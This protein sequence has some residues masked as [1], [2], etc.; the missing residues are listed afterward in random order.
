MRLAMTVAL[1]LAASCAAAET[2]IT[3]ATWNVESDADTKPATISQRM[4]QF[5]D[6]HL[7]TLVE[8]GSPSDAERYRRAV[9]QASGRNYQLILNSAKPS[10]DDRIAF[11]LDAT[12]WRLV[13]HA[14]ELTDL[15][16]Q[17][18][19][20]HLPQNQ[21]PSRFRPTFVVELQPTGWTGDRT[22]VVAA[23]HL[24]R[25]QG[26][27]NPLRN[28]QAD[29]LNGL[30]EGRISPG[31]GGL[32]DALRRK[33]PFLAMGD[34]NFDWSVPDGPGNGGFAALT[35]NDVFAWVRPAV[36][37][38]T[39]CSYNSI[40]DFVFRANSAKDWAATSR[41]V[42]PIPGDDADAYCKRDSAGESDH[43]IVVATFKIGD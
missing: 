9:S 31:P 37:I 17:L 20:L 30:V 18:C 33:A 11:L 27:E 14:Y 32:R 10:G 39:Q 28:C 38:Q 16:R 25:G 40:L 22:I 5:P 8:V 19:L 6:V 34:F 21:R 12:R 2:Q 35:K 13:G 36:P 41:I 23:N 4:R 15:T 42:V 3:V 29:L 26:S 7:W 1:I 43:L 24:Q